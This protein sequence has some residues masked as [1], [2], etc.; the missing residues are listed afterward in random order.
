[1]KTKWDSPSKL[2][3]ARLEMDEAIKRA[4]HFVEPEMQEA[5]EQGIAEILQ[6]G[7]T[8]TIESWCIDCMSIDYDEKWEEH[9]ATRNLLYRAA[10][11]LA[12]AEQTCYRE[13][14]QHEH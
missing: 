5:F 4:L 11:E 13:A 14:L 9:A 10:W 1:M 8:C 7:G 12:Q 2:T 6:E 3:Q